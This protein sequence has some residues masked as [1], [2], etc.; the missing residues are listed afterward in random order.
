MT[1]GDMSRGSC[2]LDLWD[3]QFKSGL[4]DAI[5]TIATCLGGISF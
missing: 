4:T 5:T 1:T 2:S 3:D